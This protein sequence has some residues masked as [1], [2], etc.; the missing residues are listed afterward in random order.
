M[1]S[2]TPVDLRPDDYLQA[3]AEMESSWRRAPA[4]IQASF[5]A[6]C[7]KFEL[8]NELE[9]EA[10]NKPCVFY[11]KGSATRYQATVIGSNLDRKTIVVRA[12]K[13]VI[14]VPVEL[15]DSF[16][17]T[18]DR[19]QM[20]PKLCRWRKLHMQRDLHPVPVVVYVSIDEA[21]KQ[22]CWY[23]RKHRTCV[24]GKQCWFFHEDVWFQ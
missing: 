20:V 15:L 19:N 3:Q 5:R 1:H 24:Y 11:L 17:Y 7:N 14:V 6:L 13:R 9:P 2:N 10:K 18:N 22:Y 8:L 23:Y 21:E 16:N 12:L 4:N